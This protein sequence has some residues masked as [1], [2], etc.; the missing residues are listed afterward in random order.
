MSTIQQRAAEGLLSTTLR[1]SARRSREQRLAS[2]ARTGRFTRPTDAP[3][4]RLTAAVAA[5]RALAAN[6]TKP[7]RK[8]LS[9]A[10]RRAADALAREA[11]PACVAC[12]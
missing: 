8:P 11:P 10:A 7:S 4:G 6:T 12:A 2:S 5:R 1:Q 9:Q 3:G